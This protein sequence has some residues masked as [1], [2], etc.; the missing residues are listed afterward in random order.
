MICAN[1]WGCIMWMYEIHTSSIILYLE[2]AINLQLYCAI[3]FLKP[4]LRGLITVTYLYS[5]MYLYLSRIILRVWV[6]LLA[7]EINLHL[8]KVPP[9][10]IMYPYILNI[11]YITMCIV[12]VYLCIEY[13]QIHYLHVLRYTYVFGCKLQLW[14]WKWVQG[15]N[16]LFVLKWA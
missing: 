16:I 7:F 13:I 11:L 14:A 15:K 3:S 2:L 1:Q 5:T 12:H 8:K 9:R 6:A 10:Y 4:L